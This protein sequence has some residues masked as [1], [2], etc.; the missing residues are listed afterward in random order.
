MLL[1]LANSLLICVFTAQSQINDKGT[2][3]VV[4]V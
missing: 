3:D 2:F 1:Y 4:C